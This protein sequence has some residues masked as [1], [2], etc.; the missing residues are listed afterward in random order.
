M[1]NSEKLQHLTKLSDGL[2]RL[3]TDIKAATYHDLEVI[4]IDGKFEAVIVF[5][6]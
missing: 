1:K 2:F 3:E 6:T 4:E 5:D